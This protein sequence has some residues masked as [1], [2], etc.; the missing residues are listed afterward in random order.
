MAGSFIAKDNWLDD[1]RDKQS[2]LEV[3]RSQIVSEEDAEADAESLD[4]SKADTQ[5]IYDTTLSHGS[6]TPHTAFLKLFPTYPAECRSDDR[7]NEFLEAY[8]DLR[9]EPDVLLARAH[10]QWYRHYE[11]VTREESSDE[12]TLKDLIET[13]KVMQPNVEELDKSLVEIE[14]AVVTD[15]DSDLKNLKRSKQIARWTVILCFSTGAGLNLVFILLGVE[16]RV[17]AG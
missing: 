15:A 10:L 2:A 12:K 1:I 7:V 9:L 16:V 14:R 5:A 8:P 4:L 13:A 3:A 17:D 6:L 11:E